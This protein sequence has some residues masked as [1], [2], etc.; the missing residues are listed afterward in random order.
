MCWFTFF[1]SLIHSR[2]LLP[3]SA[4]VHSRGAGATRH[5]EP[6]PPAAAAAT[7]SAPPTHPH[8]TGTQ[9]GTAHVQESRTSRS[10]AVE[11]ENVLALF[12]QRLFIRAGHLK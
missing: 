8:Q 6:C 3:R 9:T 1:S 5:Y 4:S 7:A 2:G 11:M 10:G 12:G